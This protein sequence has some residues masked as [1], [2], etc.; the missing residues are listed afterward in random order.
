MDRKYKSTTHNY[1]S[2]QNVQIYEFNHDIEIITYLICECNS[3][4]NSNLYDKT[5]HIRAVQY[6]YDYSNSKN[7]YDKIEANS[8]FI[9]DV[10]L[11]KKIRHKLFCCIWHFLLE[12]VLTHCDQDWV[13]SNA[14]YLMSKETNPKQSKMNIENIKFNLNSL[15]WHVDN[16]L[17]THN[18]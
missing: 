17:Y 15:K 6:W 8:K 18:Q 14:N 13:V 5:F 9:V 2:N 11:E 7:E 1:I 4:V 3:N 16:N 12:T 10:L